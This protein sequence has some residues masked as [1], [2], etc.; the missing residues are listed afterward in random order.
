M[1]TES[2]GESQMEFQS[3]GAAWVKAL[4]QQVCRLDC[5][6]ERMRVEDWSIREGRWLIRRSE[7]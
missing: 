1:N 3:Q 5:G 7:R 6:V 2:E 4:S